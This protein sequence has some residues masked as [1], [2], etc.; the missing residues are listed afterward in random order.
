MLSH[1]R[2]SSGSCAEKVLLLRCYL[3]EKGH[4]SGRGQGLA[5]DTCGEQEWE[6]K[7]HPALGNNFEGGNIISIQRSFSVNLRFL[8]S[9]HKVSLAAPEGLPGNIISPTNSKVEF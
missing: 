4:I 8:S 1:V 9:P 5:L 3:S 7:Y 6:L 2:V